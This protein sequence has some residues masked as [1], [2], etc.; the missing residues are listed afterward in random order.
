MLNIMVADNITMKNIEKVGRG[1]DPSKWKSASSR[2]D[3]VLRKLILI[4]SVHVILIYQDCCSVERNSWKLFYAHMYSTQFVL[5]NI[6][7]T[8]QYKKE[9]VFVPCV[10]HVQDIFSI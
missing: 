4:I 7:L 10:T 6:V 2:C 1:M 3:T 8:E 9:E 5:L